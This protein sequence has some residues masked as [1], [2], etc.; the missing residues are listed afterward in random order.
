MK[1]FK[2]NKG[3]NA[4]EKPSQKSMSEVSVLGKGI[5]TVKDLFAP[6]SFDRGNESYM[7]VGNKYVRSFIMNGFPANVSVG[8]LDQ[9]FNYDG[10]MDTAIYV[11]PTDERTALDELTA[12]I[13]QFEAQLQMEYQ[14][15]NIKNI[16]RLKNNVTQLYDQRERLERNYENLFHVQIASNLYTDSVEELE[17]ETQ[18]LDN[19][20]KGRKIFHM[21]VY[22]RQ[23][24][25]YKTVLPFGKSYIP[26][27]FRNFNSGALTAC[28]PFYNSEISHAT[29]VF[30]GV[31]I[32]TMT[33]MLV[34]FYDRDK[35]LNGNLTVFGQAGSG[36]TFL[37]SML[38]LR[39][40]LKGVRTVIID[41]EGEYKKLT[42]AV[43]GSHIYIAP[44]SRTHINPFDLEESE[45]TDEEIAEGKPE[46]DI[47]GK[48][49][50]VLNLIAVMAGGLNREEQSSVSSI[51]NE[52]YQD[53]GFNETRQSLYVTEPIFNEDTGEFY[54]DGVKKP[55][56]T[57]S[58]FHN[59]L[60]Q[61]AN[62][63]N[64]DRLTRLANAL[65]MFKKGGV[66]D[67]FDCQTSDDLKDF[68]NSPIVTFDISRLE[69]S[70]LR[71]I[72]M[73][74][75][76]S[77][78]WEKFIKKNPEIKKRIVCDEA[79]ML[80]NKNMAGFEYTAQFLENA[81]R[82]IRKRNGGLLV[83]SQN[84]VE[85]ANNDQGK[86]VLTNAVTNIFLRQDATDIDA[87]QDTF[88]LS[89][90]ERNFLLSAKKGEFLIKMNG[91]SSVA[92]AMSFPYE[93]ELISKAY[94]SKD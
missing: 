65:N 43:G 55:M 40:A 62:E 34:D 67:M 60:V 39:S 61:W 38:T 20:L 70:V 18:K 85:F 71:P 56:P 74:I 72:G 69:E 92:Y 73:Y 46:V 82:R 12:K 42:K 22:L 47:K 16:T 89:D 30:L 17:K 35:L 83:A 24:D 84:F 49:S 80:V 57:F 75:A 88:K 27:K 7:K 8:W 51:I 63:K 23:D 37:V 36:K 31:N 76:L 52:V 93:K 79:W 68:K 50:D 5:R 13:T 87:V 66:Y 15:G 94:V 28:F 10:D 91:E 11:E 41:P 45:L 19:K 54:H 90:G 81:A 32:S 25:G 1:K 4:K 86:A 33:P 14:K 53:Q 77:W 78:T 29:G 26:D 64:N 2:K 58:T 9:L 48:V 6:P 3:V 21:P 44:D 59:K